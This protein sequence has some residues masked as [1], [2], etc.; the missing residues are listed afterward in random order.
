MNRF[1]NSVLSG[2]GA[3]AVTMVLFTAT[4][5][6]TATERRSHSSICHYFN[7]TAGSGLYNGAY[8]STDSTG[9][10][11]YCPVVT[12]NVLFHDNVVT[13]NVHGYEAAGESNYSYACSVDPWSSASSCGTTTYW[14]SGWNGGGSLGTGGWTNRAWFPYIYNYVDSLGR[15]HGYYIAN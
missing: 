2:I 14:S 12:D 5:E 4:D 6:A 15:L 13:I 9:R 8:I 10:G 3:Y 11:I 7:D 1:R